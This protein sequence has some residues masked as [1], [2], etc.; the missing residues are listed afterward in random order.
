MYLATEVATL[1]TQKTGV[2][3]TDN[4]LYQ[5]L[6]SSDGQTRFDFL[7]SVHL[8]KDQ[9]QKLFEQAL[10]APAEFIQIVERW[11]VNEQKRENAKLLAEQKQQQEDAA[12]KQILQTKRVT[13]VLDLL[14]KTYGVN[15]T[16]RESAARLLV[17]GHTTKQAVEKLWK[18][19]KFRIPVIGVIKRTTSRSFK[20]YYGWMRVPM[21]IVTVLHKNKKLG[22]AVF[23]QGAWAS[24]AKVG[25]RLKLKMTLQD[26]QVSHPQFRAA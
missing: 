19:E 5:G 3:I 12:V 7:P 16:D 4:H 14:N 1:L 24:G 11:K 22:D 21:V 8:P 26:G 20:G 9:K 17:Q 2:K 18:T 6:P 13:N 15:L 23:D 10:N 25:D